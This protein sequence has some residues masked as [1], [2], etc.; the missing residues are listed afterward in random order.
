MNKRILINS[1]LALFVCAL[2][3]VVWFKPGQQTDN[4]NRLTALDPSS[5]NKIIIERKSA[6]SIELSRHDNQWHI[7]QP[8]PALALPGKIERLLKI[9]QIK[10]LAEYPLDDS[11]LSNLGLK[12]PVAKITYNN[13]QLLIGGTEP[14][15]TRRYVAN[16]NKLFL[17]DDTF[18]HHLTAPVEAYID[19]RLIA[20]N[21]QIIELKTP[22]M[23]LLRNPD[24]TW[25]DASQPSL[26]LS[27]DAVQTLLDEW[28]FARA[29]RVKVNKKISS[30]A[31]VFISLNNGKILSFELFKEQQQRV[32]TS[33]KTALSYYFSDDKYKKMTQLPDQPDA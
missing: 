25:K 15:Q 21:T 4:I 11:Q 6:G 28:R 29:I 20:D 10:G 24:N 5:I 9:S 30:N 12:E 18:I 32:L 27:S 16:A 7:T 13:V 2:A 26:S 31:N 1:L 23:H 14:V 22:E 33:T 3:L 17:V 19:T 8:I